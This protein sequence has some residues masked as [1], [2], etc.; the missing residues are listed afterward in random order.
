MVMIIIVTLTTLL[1]IKS[2]KQFSISDI[3]VE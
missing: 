2:M 3:N 1:S